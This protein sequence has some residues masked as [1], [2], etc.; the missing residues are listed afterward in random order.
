MRLYAAALALGA[1]LSIVPPAVAQDSVR[2]AAFGGTA[3]RAGPDSSSRV[4][5]QLAQDEW[6]IPDSAGIL[7]N[8]FLL[9][10][11]GADTG[12]L[13][14]TALPEASDRFDDRLTAVVKPSDDT[15]EARAL[16]QRLA[17]WR[18]LP[19]C[20]TVPPGPFPFALLKDR[21]GV[22][23]LEF[24]Y[25]AGTTRQTLRIPPGF[26]TDFASIPRP[27]WSVL[28]PWDEYKLSAVIHDY[29][30]W[31]QPCTK[32][33]ADNLLFIAMQEEGV[34]AWKRNVVYAG[35]AAGGQRAWDANKARRKRGA[36]RWVPKNFNVPYVT[37]DSL[38]SLLEK[39]HTADPPLPAVP[40]AFCAFGDRRQVP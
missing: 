1:A 11:A 39:A 36:S 30:Y 22:T 5:R 32:S 34:A 38:L 17:E 19:C 21:S 9:I 10:R 7:R 33:Q 8:G 26:V 4:K 20:A 18:R 13:D 31:A 25:R 15:L 37:G 35:V 14:L 16:E 12:W 2:V 40:A 23:Q 24:A 3:L 29:L 28:A 27:L 6:V